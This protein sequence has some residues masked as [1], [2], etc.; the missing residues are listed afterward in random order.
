MIHEQIL[1]MKVD[2]RYIDQHIYFIK[3]FY[4]NG[5]QAANNGRHC[6]IEKCISTRSTKKVFIVIS[7]K[8]GLRHHF[9]VKTLKI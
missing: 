2:N 8:L 7:L 5:E 9:L 3:I 1:T 6:Y 4:E